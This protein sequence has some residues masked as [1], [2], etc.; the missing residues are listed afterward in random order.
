M[1]YGEYLLREQLGEAPT[2]AEYLER[3]PEYAPRLRQQLEFHQALEA[4]PS[5]RAKPTMLVREGIVQ[6]LDA[7]APPPTVSCWP[8]VQ[9]Y[10]ILG[11]LGRGGMGVVY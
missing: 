10:E 9:G 6:A 11:E 3:F 8:T 7:L 2:R 5:L 1:I 4:I